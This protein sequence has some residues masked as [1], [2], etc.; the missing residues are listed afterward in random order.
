MSTGEAFEDFRW[1]LRGEPP[2]LSP[3]ARALLRALA[4]NREW[5][6][7]SPSWLAVA[8]WA[9]ELVEGKPTGEEVA[10][11]LEELRERRAA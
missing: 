6:G 2:G 11:A 9:H 4:D 7:E 10:A 3:L 8:L 5:L 1:R